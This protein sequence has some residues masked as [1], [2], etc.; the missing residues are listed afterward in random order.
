VKPQVQNSPVILSDVL[1]A[2]NRISNTDESIFLK[3]SFNSFFDPNN[4]LSIS[5]MIVF[6]N[7]IESSSRVE[8]V[9]EKL[10]YVI[11]LLKVAHA[12]IN[13]VTFE[14]HLD[15]GF[16]KSRQ[17]LDVIMKNFTAKRPEYERESSP[18]ITLLTN[19]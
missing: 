7:L 4:H 12:D 18:F 2:N 15:M 16:M 14:N 1:F 8:V 11:L 6:D 3:M 10:I 5:N 19:S 17:V 13:N 9:R